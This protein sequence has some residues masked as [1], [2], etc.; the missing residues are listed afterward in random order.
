VR[1]TLLVLTALLAVACAAPALAGGDR[2]APRRKKERKRRK[3]RPKLRAPRPLV[4]SC[5]VLSR[6]GLSEEQ[7]AKVK[8]LDEE[9]RKKYEEYKKQAGEDQAK[10]AEL[11]KKLWELFRESRKKVVALLTE[12]QKKKYDEGMEILRGY[13]PKFGALKQAY[14][15]ARERAGKDRKKHKEIS[16][17]FRAKRKELWTEV[18]KKLDE[19]VGKRPGREKKKPDDPGKKP[20]GEKK[21]EKQPPGDDFDF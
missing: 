18:N 16:D 9:I 15:K 11:N 19:K 20:E 7:M 21:P 8:P 6:L 17:N 10:Q 12:E 5:H 14:A 1:K 4:A 13:Y 2:E 3:V